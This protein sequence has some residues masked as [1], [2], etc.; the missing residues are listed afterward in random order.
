M[1]PVG[2]Q[3][4]ACR[5]VT[6]QGEIINPVWL[7]PC[8]L[9]STLGEANHCHEDTQHLTEVLGAGDSGLLPTAGTSGQPC[10][11]ITSGVRPKGDPTSQQA[12]WAT[13]EFLPQKLRSC[14]LSF[15]AAQLEENC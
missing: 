11:R 5:C 10:E 4:T 12:G 3:G 15:A 2:Y 8:Y 13:L 9:D 7:W 6:P 1:Q 14:V